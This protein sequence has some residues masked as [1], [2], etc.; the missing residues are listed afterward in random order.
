M[1]QGT[2]FFVPKMIHENN[3]QLIVLDRPF[4]S[5]SE[6]PFL[7]SLGGKDPAGKEKRTCR[8]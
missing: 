6:T 5:S 2:L 8:R 1:E 4:S 7:V 3:S